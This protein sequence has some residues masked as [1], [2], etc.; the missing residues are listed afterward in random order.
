MPDLAAPVM[1]YIVDIQSSALNELFVLY[2]LII[3]GAVT[4]VKPDGIANVG[5]SRALVGADPRGL[6]VLADPWIELKMLASTKATHDRIDI[7]I[8][9][10][11]NPVT[12]KTIPPGEEDQRMA[13]YVLPEFFTQGVNWLYYVVT[14]VGGNT[15]TS[16]KLSVLYNL[17][18]STSLVLT[19][20]PDV[21]AKGVDAARAAQ[22]VLFTFTYSNRRPFDRIEFLLGD[23]IIRF[24][25][26]DAPAPITRT[27]FTQD[28]EKAGD[29]PDA[30]AEF[31]VIDQLGNRAQSPEQTLDIHLGSVDL[32]APTF[33]SVKGSPSNVEIP[34]GGSTL[35]SALVFGGTG[36]AGEKIELLDKDV[37]KATIT[38]PASGNWTQTLTGQAVGAHSYTVKALYGS[39]V[40]TAARTLTVTADLWK[41]SVTDFTNGTAGSW[42]IG[43]AGRYGRITGGLFQNDTAIGQSGFSGVVFSQT[44]LFTAGRTYSFSINVRNNGP[45]AHLLPSFSVALSSGQEILPAAT[46][47]KTGQWISRVAS[48]SVS[49]TGNQTISIV[50]HQDRGSG[51]GTDGGNDYQI[52]NIIVRRLA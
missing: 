41:D 15:E 31:Y 50:S 34:N 28:F 18:A 5:V 36:P 29:S 9:G 42:A 21:L 23:T 1:E 26:P 2:P 4:P 40:E 7:Y 12:G 46:V 38:I 47:P 52:D 39:G 24:D 16:R 19:I 33:T 6:E 11:P 17:R 48:F 51:S 44:F 10:N 27:L 35:D 37:F 49:Q 22:G 8:E 14:R 20:P 25:V 3:Q 30:V 32:P 43:S 45:V 13:L